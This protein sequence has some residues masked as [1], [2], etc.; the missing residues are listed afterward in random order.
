L[1]RPRVLLTGAS[2]RL[3]TG[4][5]ETLDSAW[6]VVGQSVSGATGTMAADLSTPGGRRLALDA[7][8]DLAVNAAAV[9]STA[10]CREHP[11]AAWAVNVLWPMEL[12]RECFSR[13]APLIHFS[14]DLVHSGGVPPYEEDSPAAPR[15]LY[16]WTKLLADMLVTRVH[17]GALVLRTSVLFGEISGERTTF[18]GDLLR[19]G[20]RSVYVDCWR[21]HTPVHWLASILPELLASGATGKVIAA[22][23]YSTS[24]SAFAE[25]LLEHVGR[26]ASGLEFSYA[27]EGTPRR[28]HLLPDL[29]ERL[30]GR[31][32][33][34]V[35]Q[36]IA[37]EYEGQT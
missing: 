35:A 21:N 26:D 34:D 4:I 6:D 17:P 25:A 16:G 20:V 19:G 15:S 1:S 33:P 31:G 37:I 2:G 29:L 24:R 8:F 32:A 3:G 11:S 10:L 36:S 27:P 14:S 28:L 18:S 13:G 22:A 9:S 30:L 23:R 7:P 12:A 5:R